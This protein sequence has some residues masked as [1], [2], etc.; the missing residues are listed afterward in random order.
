[1]YSDAPYHQSV[2]SILEL[3]SPFIRS[4][5]HHHQI[6]PVLKLK[7]RKNELVNIDPASG[8]TIKKFNDFLIS[9]SKK[10]FTQIET[11]FKRKIFY[12]HKLGFINLE[13]LIKT[14]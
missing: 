13:V 7:N 2:V 11:P 14:A 5:A 8:T 3:K 12:E 9:F 6:V 10:M 1:M 4:K